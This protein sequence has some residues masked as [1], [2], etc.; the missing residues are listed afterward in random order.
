MFKQY[1][2]TKKHHFGIKLYVLCDCE[3]GYVLDFI[4]YAGIN[5]DKTANK[6]SGLGFS[7]NIVVQLLQPYL[8]NYRSPTLSN[9]LFE[10]K[11][12]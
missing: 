3:T 8:D 4:V 12:N 6:D 5:H 11:T 10:H 2:K 1:I 9:Y 7:G